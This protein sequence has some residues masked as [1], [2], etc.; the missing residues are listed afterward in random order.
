MKRLMVALT[1]VLALAASPILAGYKEM[2]VKDG[3]TIRG[4]VTYKG[5][6]PPK[7]AITKDVEACGTETPDPSIVSKDGKLANVLVYLKKVKKGKAFTAAQKAVVSDQNCCIFEP[8]VLLV[9]EG[10][11][12]T[13]KNSDSVLHNVKSSSLKNPP[14][15]EGVEAGKSMKKTFKNGH[16]E[17]KITCSVH[18]WMAGYV[19]VMDNPYYAVTDENGNFE[20]KDV[21]P[22]KYKVVVWHESMGKD[23]TVAVDGGKAESQ[24]KSGTKVKMKK[25]GRIKMAIGYEK[26]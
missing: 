20:I 7:T 2:E 1:G 24:S 17:V 4:T 8:H 21:P 12:V 11:T 9:A 23:C 10:G 26:S 19:I 13:F 5:K 14:F 16:E 6:V 25:G 18:P 15:N 3:G 22:G